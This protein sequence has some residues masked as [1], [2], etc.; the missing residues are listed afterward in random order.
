MRRHV[1]ILA[2]I[3]L[4]TL[5]LAPGVTH[6]LTFE[7]DSI[8]KWDLPG[9]ASLGRLSIVAADEPGA[10]R[11]T[12]EVDSPWLEV[13]KVWFNVDPRINAKGLELYAGSPAGGFERGNDEL[14]APLTWNRFDLLWKPDKK[15][16]GEGG[17][18][19]KVKMKDGAA[20]E[21]HHFLFLSAPQGKN[22]PL[23]FLVELGS[24]AKKGGDTVGGFLKVST[25]GGTFGN[26]PPSQV[27]LPSAVG[28]MLPGL[29]LILLM[30][31]RRRR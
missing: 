26:L 14:T 3:T 5:L 2:A 19:F 4:G 31:R 23:P 17:Y 9:D 22:D 25:T 29:A 20:L 1:P 24:A 12:I 10:V 28:L 21:P 30:G 16:E 11:F 13:R 6:A 15:G 8:L 7:L 27:P 18:S